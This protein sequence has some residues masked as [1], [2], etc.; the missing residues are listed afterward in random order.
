MHEAMPK[1][2]LNRGSGAGVGG[3]AWLLS[4]LLAAFALPLLAL[5]AGRAFAHADSPGS[6]PLA[7]NPLRLKYRKPAEIVAL[8]ARERL[9]DAPGDHI[10][11]AARSAEEESL[12]PAGVD[13]VLRGEDLD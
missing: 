4:C 5:S 10:P 9:P 2:S 7:P 12:V 13:A 8:F 11:R 1:P 3:R 6:P